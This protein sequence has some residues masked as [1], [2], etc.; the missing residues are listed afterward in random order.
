MIAPVMVNARDCVGRRVHPTAAKTSRDAEEALVHHAIVRSRALPRVDLCCLL[1]MFHSTSL[2]MQC[3]GCLPISRNPALQNC[4]SIRVGVC[5]LPSTWVGA[6]PIPSC[7]WAC[8]SR[9]ACPIR[10]MSITIRACPR[11]EFLRRSHQANIQSR[12]R[13]VTFKGV[14]YMGVC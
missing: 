4:P 2:P 9:R 1:P 11:H 10:H 3:T 12:L 13:R 8:L 5:F 6:T 7:P 14:Y